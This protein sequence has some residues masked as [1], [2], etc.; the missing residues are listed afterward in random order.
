MALEH[1]WNSWATNRKDVLLI[2][3]GSAA[4]WMLNTL[5]NN[6]GG[7]HNRVTY[8]MMVEPF[9]LHEADLLLKANGCVFDHYQT[10][11][12]YMVTG[13]VPFYLEQIQPGLS[14]AQNIERLCFRKRGLL[15]LEFNNLFS[16]LFKKSEKHEALIQALA[17][18]PLGLTRKA[19]AGITKF[20][21]GGSLTRYLNEL[22]ESGF[23]ASFPV[24]GKKSSTHSMYR[25]VD[26]YSLFY[27]KFIKNNNDFDEGVW[28]QS[29]DHPAQRAWFGHAFELVCLQHIDQ[30]KKALHIGGVLTRQSY[31]KSKSSENGAQIDLVIDRRDQVLNLCE[32]KFSI[33]QFS[34][35]KDYA[36]KLRNKIGSF[37]EETNTRKTTFLTF[38]STFGLK[39][40][41]HSQSLVQQSLTMEVLFEK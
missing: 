29:V 18:K 26:F 8:R 39:E 38:I 15:A 28:V 19:L 34:I 27:L 17:Q 33:N 37:R 13:G 1:F 7:L 14:A 20:S 10:L 11:Q 22:E 41:M 16:S 23:I 21:S 3:C 36:A 25:L 2:T 12:I 35:S 24:F 30:I 4:S 31:W 9:T 5:I 32:I 40:N 6:H